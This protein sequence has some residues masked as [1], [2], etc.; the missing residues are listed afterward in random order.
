MTYLLLLL[1]VLLWGLHRVQVKREYWQ[2]PY[3]CDQW[4]AFHREAL[5][6]CKG[7]PTLK[8]AKLPKI[9]PLRGV[10][11]TRWALLRRVR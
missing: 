1:P 3:L 2:G 5:K 7:E 8:L 4:R 6:P 11:V 9:K 10:R